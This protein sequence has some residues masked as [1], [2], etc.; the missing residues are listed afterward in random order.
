MASV[1]VHAD[2]V[3]KCYFREVNAEY[4]LQSVTQVCAVGHVAVPGQTSLRR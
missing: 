4:L 2:L 3:G 1:G